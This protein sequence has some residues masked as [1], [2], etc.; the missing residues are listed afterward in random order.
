MALALVCAVS[1][2]FPISFGRNTVDV[3]D[4]VV[5]T[6]LIW[7]GPLWALL[8]AVPALLCRDRLRTIYDTSNQAIMILTAGWALQFFSGPLLVV[9]QFYSSLVYGVLAA[10]V[11]Y[12]ML[13]ALIGSTL[14]YL[15]YGDR[16]DDTIREAFFPLIPSDVAAFL[17]ALGASYLLVSFGPAAALVLFIG[18]FGALVSLQLIWGRQQENEALKEENARLRESLNASGVAFA[19]RLVRLLG[20]KNGNVPAQA[21]AAAVYAADIAREMGLDEDQVDKVRIS[22]LLRDVGLAGLPDEV[23]NVPFERLKPLGKQLYRDHPVRSEQVISG[24]PEFE[25][26]AKWVRWHH[27][28]ADGTGYPDRL[29]PDWIPVEA[30]IL[31]AAGLY[32]GKVLDSPYEVTATALEARRT[33]T[34]E[35]GAALDREVVR[36]FLS[37]LDSHGEDYALAAGEQFAFPHTPERL[38]PESRNPGLRVVGSE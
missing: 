28:R 7:L 21:A 6:A 26:A 2:R 36:A 14:A 11:V 5:L 30:K 27:E 3:I 29:R 15:K 17:T 31:A 25:E 10:G 16:I 12:Y 19:A 13:D 4:V 37:V 32:A 23:L 18:A 8:I 34:G 9:P 35:I 24:I 1:R 20:E 22:A 38:A 33:L